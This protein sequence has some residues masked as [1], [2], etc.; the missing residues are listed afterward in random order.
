MGQYANQVIESKLFKQFDALVSYEDVG[1][2]D[3]TKLKQL[4]LD[5]ADFVGPHLDRI[6]DTFKQYTEHDLR[7]LCNVADLIYRFLP[8]Q[9]PKKETRPSEKIRLNAVELAFLRPGILLHDI[10]MYVSDAEKLQTVDSDDYRNFLNLNQDQV[11]AVQI[12]RKQGVELKART[13]EDA[14]LAVYYRRLHAERV[15]TY[16]RDKLQKSMPLA[17]NDVTL[18]DYIADLCESHAWGVRESND[19]R[20]SSKCV[21]SM[22]SNLHIRSFRVNLRHLACCLRLGDI[23]DFDKSRT[24]LSVYEEI[25]F[26]EE[27]P[28]MEWNKHLSINGWHVDEHHVLFNASCTHPA[29]YVA[30][31]DFLNWVD[32]ELRECRYLLD[33]TPAG[34]E[35]KYALCLAH[36][37]DRRQVRMHDKKFVAGGFRFRLE[38]EE[39]MRL[40]MDKSLYPDST[41]FLRELLQNALD[42]CRYQ[43]A[44][45]KEAGMGDKYKPRIMVFDHSEDP[46]EPRIVFQDNGIGMSQRH[47]EDFFLR[48]GKSFYRSHE[49]AAEQ[50]RLSTYG[51]HLDACSQFGIGFLSCFLGGDRIE[52]ETWRHGNAP[53]KIII[54]GPS[55]YFLIER[56]PETTGSIQFK[57]PKNE[58]E[59]GPPKYPGT[60]I[61]VHLKD[62]WHSI[63][64]IPAEGIVH[65]TL[66]SFAVNQEYDICI[67]KDSDA[68]SIT[69]KGRRWENS[70]PLFCNKLNNG[71][72]DIFPFLAPSLFDF[73]DYSDDLRGQGA[74][75]MLK[76]SN[77]NPCPESGDYYLSANVFD[78]SI[79]MSE[80]LKVFYSLA[81]K[82]AI[83]DRKIVNEF[84]DYL[85]ENLMLS[86]FDIEPLIQRAHIIDEGRLAWAIERSSLASYE[87]AVERKRLAKLFK[88][89][90]FTN[91]PVSDRGLDI[92]NLFYRLLFEGNRDSLIDNTSTFGIPHLYDSFELGTA[93][94]LGAF[95]IDVPGRVVKWEPSKG[96]A[97]T[98]TMLPSS[99]TA[100]IDA[101][102]KLAPQP[103]ASRLFVNATQVR[104]LH[105][106]LGLAI[107]QHAARLYREHRSIRAWERWY[108][109]FLNICEPIA[110]AVI[111]EIST[112]EEHFKIP[113]LL[114]GEFSYQTPRQLCENYGD[115]VSVLEQNLP[116]ELELIGIVSSNNLTEKPSGELHGVINT[117]TSNFRN[118]W[119]PR[120]L[121]RRKLI[122]GSEV[123]DLT[124]LRAK[125]EM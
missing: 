55:K 91:I 35:E 71:F 13:I 113:C 43:E 92:T 124:T 114:H 23:L 89:I 106:A 52:V 42:A 48:V 45:A 29:Y 76:D 99:V 58:L 18:L 22:E 46:D 68:E 87:D 2:V 33:E 26:T 86:T 10:G 80:D 62:S 53:L 100:R 60:R 24:P 96:Y 64:E 121:P 101:Y 63:S 107:L 70:A 5:T 15:R 40:L 30:V 17:F 110:D 67:Y 69:I 93:F 65:E 116:R 16:M 105:K 51:I 78:L 95:G 6:R 75:W 103:N 54:T 81:E 98:V 108:H 109:G 120:N 61:T 88:R 8:K 72:E 125:F 14:L 118:D 122:D 21:A 73:H 112:I 25:D 28:V 97:K 119:F 85:V 111:E 115:S 31:H 32:A 39:I 94:Q 90:E 12:A 83:V 38:Y 19:P 36:A 20:D 59:D 47:V 27:K 11:A 74:I 102:G 79:K 7:H 66:N 84:V 104:P 41:L 34:D 1:E 82:I 49:F 44:L 4:V 3:I 56:L 77:G 37:V 117:V 123:I 57:S 9:P 50:Q